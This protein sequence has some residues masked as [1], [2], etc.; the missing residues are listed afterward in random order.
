MVNPQGITYPRRLRH[1]AASL[2]VAGKKEKA[3]RDAG[4]EEFAGSEPRA[5]GW[6]LEAGGAESCT[7]TH[8]L[9]AADTAGD[10]QVLSKVISS[11]KKVITAFAER[12]NWKRQNLQ[13]DELTKQI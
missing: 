13:T 5:A 4:S 1:S 8:P 9:G 3:V 7:R 6:G 10:G 2:R 11:W 12:K